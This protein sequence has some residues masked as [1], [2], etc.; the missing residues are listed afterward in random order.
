ETHRWVVAPAPLGNRLDLVLVSDAEMKQ[1]VAQIAP[2]RVPALRRGA[3]RQ[4][5]I[6]SNARAQLGVHD[7]IG[8]DVMPASVQVLGDG[9]VVHLQKRVAGVEE[10]SSRTL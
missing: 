9:A 7:A 5:P 10:D 2:M 6:Q 1:D 3:G 4:M 8:V